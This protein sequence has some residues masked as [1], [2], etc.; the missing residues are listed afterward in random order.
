M[1]EPFWPWWRQKKINTNMK[2]LNAEEASLLKPIKHSRET[3]FSA[4]LK[5]LQVGEAIVLEAK[6][7]KTKTAPYRV[8]NRIAKQNGWSFEQGRMADGS[9]WVFK[10]VG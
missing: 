8:S 4:M 10:R 2:K 6:D 1:A 9:G 7:W 5:Q 3:L